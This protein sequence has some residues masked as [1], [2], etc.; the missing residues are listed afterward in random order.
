[1]T[2]GLEVGVAQ[3]VADTAA[4]TV[5]LPVLSEVT[6]PLRTSVVEPDGQPDPAVA[7]WVAVVC[8]PLC[9][10][11]WPDVSVIVPLLLPEPPV[12]PVHVLS[13][14]LTTPVEVFAVPLNLLQLIPLGAAPAGEAASALNPTTGARTAA[15]AMD[16]CTIRFLIT[17]SILL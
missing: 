3:M 7:V 16:P 13:L 12:F 5:V 1:M 6:L 15:T 8:F 11:T 4:P 17:V 14:V 9:H 10:L 2:S